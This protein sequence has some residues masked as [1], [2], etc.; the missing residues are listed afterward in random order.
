MQRKD[1]VYKLNILGKA[2]FCFLG[3]VGICM[4]GGFTLHLSANSFPLWGYVFNVLLILIGFYLIILA[5]QYRIILSKD[6]VTVVY[7]F[8]V[9]SLQRS[10]VKGRKYCRGW[11]GPSWHFLLANNPSRKRLTILND[12]GFNKEWEDWYFALPDL[13]Y[14][15]KP[16]IYFKK[17][18]KH[19]QDK[20]HP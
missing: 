12:V 17:N 4:F 9:R 13:D 3:F 18:G 1:S 11:D 20:R 6:T 2:K 8:S 14:P 16:K 10:E 19:T 15:Q 5:F 7:P